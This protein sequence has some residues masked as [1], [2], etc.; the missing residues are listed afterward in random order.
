MDTT[1]SFFEGQIKD[2]YLNTSNAVQRQLCQTSSYQN[3]NREYDQL[4]DRIEALLP[5][6]ERKLIEALRLAESELSDLFCEALF[7]KGIHLGLKLS[8]YTG[9]A[10]H[11]ACLIVNGA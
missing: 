10:D 5:E 7:A 1:A 3:A 4:L 8:V 11:P 6:N 2:V 9:F